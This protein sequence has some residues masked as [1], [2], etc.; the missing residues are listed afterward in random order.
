MI[1][2]EPAAAAGG[3]FGALSGVADE[4]GDFEMEERVLAETGC[5]F[6]EDAVLDAVLDVVLLR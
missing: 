3:G 2:D 5:S 1:V 6:V 4:E